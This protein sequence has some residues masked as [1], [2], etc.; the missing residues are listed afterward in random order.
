MKEKM[1][2]VMT[3][4]FSSLLKYIPVKPKIKENAKQLERKKRHYLNE[5]T[6]HQSFF[7]LTV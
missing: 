3:K 1:G 4:E 6:Q 5:R 2:V 7:F